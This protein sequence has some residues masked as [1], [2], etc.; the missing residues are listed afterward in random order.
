M[1]FDDALRHACL[2]NAQVI[3][4]SML[5]GLV[6]ALSKEETWKLFVRDNI[7]NTDTHF[8]KVFR[9]VDTESTASRSRLASEMMMEPSPV[10]EVLTTPPGNQVIR[11][12]APEGLRL[13]SP[14][15]SAEAPMDAD[16]EDSDS[17]GAS[18]VSDSTRA[19]RRVIRREVNQDMLGPQGQ[20]DI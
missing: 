5:P 6:T 7:A 3:N 14:A 12:P 17:S 20:M 15:G 10:L 4:T 8:S 13:P 16:P 9:D 19:A 18:P 11:D 1:S 2:S